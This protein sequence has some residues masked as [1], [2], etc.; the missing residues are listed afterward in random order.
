MSNALTP[1][2]HRT[3]QCAE[4]VKRPDGV[5]EVVQVKGA[6]IYFG[7][8]ESFYDAWPAPTCLVV[9][10]PYGVS[11]YPGDLNTATGLAEWYEPHARAWAKRATPETTLWF[12]CS[13]LGWAAVHHV[14]ERAGWDYRGCHTWNKGLAHIAGNSNTQTLRKFPVATEVCVQYVRRPEFRSLDGDLMSMQEW[15]RHEWTRSGLPLRAANEACGV[16]NAA[17][18]K[19][20]APD[21]LW[22][23]PPP[24]AFEKL[25]GYANRHGNPQGR[26]YFSL[27]GKQPLSCAAWEKMRAKFKCPAGVTNVWELPHVGGSERINGSRSAQKWKYKSLHGSQKPLELVKMIIEATT[28]RNDVVWEPFGGLCPAAVA[29]VA[30]RRECR[31]AEIM[32]EF[33]AAAVKRLRHAAAGD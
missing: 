25:A 7:E 29:S 23:Y 21:H 22:Y 15:L 2:Y 1:S 24:G 10:G 9:D 30:L 8:A 13:E 18:R 6:A 16:A 31:S 4:P 32:R 20:L 27:D 11:G 17:T 26:P 14:L 19:Y 3:R 12:W 33:Y 5:P 28:D